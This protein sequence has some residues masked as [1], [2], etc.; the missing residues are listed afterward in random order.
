MFPRQEGAKKVNHS[1][2]LILDL[3]IPDSILEPTSID[4]GANTPTFSDLWSNTY[5]SPDTYL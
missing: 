3:H 2:R 1:L 5:C 4:T